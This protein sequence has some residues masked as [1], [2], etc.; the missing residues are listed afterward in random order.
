MLE[1]QKVQVHSRRS[2]PT[3]QLK[4]LQISMN[5]ILTA[6]TGQVEQVQRLLL[7]GSMQIHSC[8]SDWMISGL[9]TTTLP[10][11]AQ[12]NWDIGEKIV[13]LRMKNKNNYFFFFWK[14]K[15]HRTFSLLIINN[16]NNNQKE[17]PKQ[18]QLK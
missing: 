11:D 15:F 4:D 1:H 6:I 3:Y 16:N 9:L 8:L 7:T 12:S 2:V 5:P 14:Q 18:S 17:C 10:A 13:Q